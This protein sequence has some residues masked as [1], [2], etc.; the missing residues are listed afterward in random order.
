MGYAFSVMA[1]NALSKITKKTN[2]S[3]LNAQNG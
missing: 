1:L 3:H 2:A